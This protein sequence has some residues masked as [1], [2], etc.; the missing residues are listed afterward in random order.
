MVVIAGSIF[1]HFV[2]V[3]KILETIGDPLPTPYTFMTAYST[4]SFCGALV[5]I[6]S[7]D[8]WNHLTEFTH[9]PKLI[10]ARLDAQMVW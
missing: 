4:I 10:L 9:K 2:T 1:T 5:D 3:C 6:D 8:N 7:Y